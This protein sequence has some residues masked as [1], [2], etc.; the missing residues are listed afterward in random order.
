MYLSGLNRDS[1]EGTLRSVFRRDTIYVQLKSACYGVAL[2]WLRLTH[3]WI[4]DSQVILNKT[5]AI[6]DTITTSEKSASDDTYL[7]VSTENSIALWTDGAQKLGRFCENL[8]ARASKLSRFEQTISSLKGLHSKRPRSLSYLRTLDGSHRIQ[9][10]G[11]SYRRTTS[12]SNVADSFTSSPSFDLFD[13]CYSS[14]PTD[15]VVIEAVET[16][17][18]PVGVSTLH[19]IPRST[20]SE[21]TDTFNV[22]VSSAMARLT[23]V[24]KKFC[25]TI[26]SR[27]TEIQTSMKVVGLQKLGK[28]LEKLETASSMDT[29]HGSTSSDVECH[30]VATLNNLSDAI[31]QT[32]TW[33]A[34]VHG[35][36]ND[37]TESNSTT[38][39]TQNTHLCQ[40]NTL[41][42]DFS[43]LANEMQSFISC[44]TLLRQSSMKTL[45]KE[46]MDDTEE[47][48][49]SYHWIRADQDSSSRYLQSHILESRQH[50]QR[51]VQELNTHVMSASWD[52]WCQPDLEAIESPDMLDRVPTETCVN[53]YRDFAACLE[54]EVTRIGEDSNNSRRLIQIKPLLDLMWSKLH[55]RLKVIIRL[56]ETNQ[57]TAGA[58]AVRLMISDYSEPQQTHDSNGNLFKMS[59]E[60]IS[61]LRH[62][63]DDD[64]IQNEEMGFSSTL[65]IEVTLFQTMCALLDVVLSNP[66][67][68]FLQQV[69]NAAVERVLLLEFIHELLG[70]NMASTWEEIENTGSEDLFG[71][72]LGSLDKVIGLCDTFVN[73]TEEGSENFVFPG[74][75]PLPVLFLRAIKKLAERYNAVQDFYT[76]AEVDSQTEVRLT[77]LT[78]TCSQLRRFC[79]SAKE[80]M[81]SRKV[82]STKHPWRLAWKPY[83]TKENMA[84]RAAYLSACLTQIMNLTRQLMTIPVRSMEH[85]AEQHR[86][87]MMISSKLTWHVV[88]ATCLCCSLGSVLQ[89]EQELPQCRL[90]IDHSNVLPNAVNNLLNQMI[91]R[92][93]KVYRLQHWWEQLSKQTR[94]F[95]EATSKLCDQLPGY[96]VELAPVIHLTFVEWMNEELTKS[97]QTSKLSD[98]S[99]VVHR[100]LSS[101]Q[102]LDQLLKQQHLI[103]SVVWRLWE[104]DGIGD[105]LITQLRRFHSQLATFGPRFPVRDSFHL[106][107]WNARFSSEWT[108]L[109]SWTK[110]LLVE[111]TEC[112]HSVRWFEDRMTMF[113]TKVKS[114][115]RW[116][117]Q[118]SEMRVD[119][120][121]D[122]EALNSKLKHLELIYSEVTGSQATQLEY[123]DSGILFP[124]GD[125]SVE[126]HSLL[127]ILAVKRDQAYAMH[128]SLKR[129]LEEGMNELCSRLVTLVE[130][131]EIDSFSLFQMWFLIHL[132]NMDQ[133]QPGNQLVD[134]IER[135]RGNLHIWRNAYEKL[136]RRLPILVQFLEAHT[137]TTK[138]ALY[139]LSETWFALME[140]AEDAQERL[141]AKCIRYE[142]LQRHISLFE[143]E[144]EE[145]C[146]YSKSSDLLNY[147][148]ERSC[149]M[150]FCPAVQKRKRERFVEILFRLDKLQEEVTLFTMD[151]LRFTLPAYEACEQHVVEYQMN[152]LDLPGQVQRIQDKLNE[153]NLDPSMNDDP[154]DEWNQLN[155]QELQFFHGI[156][157]LEFLIEC[158]F[159]HHPIAI[160]EREK[161]NYFGCL[162]K[163]IGFLQ[164]K[165]SERMRVWFAA[166][167]TDCNP[168]RTCGTLDF[169]S[170]Y[171]ASCQ[172]FAD[173]LAKLKSVHVI[174]SQ[175]HQFLLDRMAL[176]EAVRARVMERAEAAQLHL[177]NI[178]QQTRILMRGCLISQR[179]VEFC[180]RK[181]V[182]DL[183]ERYNEDGSCNPKPGIT[184]V[185]D[186]LSDYHV[187]SNLS[188]EMGFE[189]KGGDADGPKDAPGLD[190]WCNLELDRIQQQIS[191]T[192]DL[193]GLVVMHKQQR[194]L[195]WAQ[196][197]HTIGN[198]TNHQPHIL[199][200][201]LTLRMKLLSILIQLNPYLSPLSMARW[202]E[203]YPNRPPATSC[204]RED[205]ANFFDRLFRLGNALK[206]I[207]EQRE[208][209]MNGPQEEIVSSESADS[210]D[211]KLSSL[212]DA[213]SKQMTIGPQLLSCSKL[214]IRMILHGD[215]HAT[216]HLLPLLS[217]LLDVNNRLFQCTT[218]VEHILERWFHFLYFRSQVSNQIL[219]NELERFRT[220]V[221]DENVNTF[222]TDD[223]I[224][225]QLTM[226]E[227]YE[228]SFSQ[229]C[230]LDEYI[231][232]PPSSAEDGHHRLFSDPV[233]IR[234]RLQ[235]KRIA[236][237][238]EAG[239]YHRAH[240][241]RVDAKILDAFS[242]LRELTTAT[243]SLSKRD[244][245]TLQDHSKVLRK[246]WV[247]VKE[248]YTE[249]G[250]AEASDRPTHIST[251]YPVVF[252]V[253]LTLVDSL[254][255]WCNILNTIL[256]QTVLSRKQVVEMRC[257]LRAI[258]DKLSILPDSG[259]NTLS[260]LPHPTALS[261][262]TS[263]WSHIEDS[264]VPHL[265]WML[266]QTERQSARFQERIDYELSRNLGWLKLLSL[267]AG[268]RNT[269]MDLTV[270]M[271][272]A[273]RVR[274]ERAQLLCYSNYEKKRNRIT[275]GI[276]QQTRLLLPT[277][278]RQSD[279]SQHHARIS[280]KSLLQQNNLQSLLKRTSMQYIRMGL[281]RMPSPIGTAE[282][283]QDFAVRLES[284]FEGCI[285]ELLKI[286]H[287]K[288]QPTPVPISKSDSCSNLDVNWPLPVD[289]WLRRLD[290]MESSKEENLVECIPEWLT[291]IKQL[292][293]ESSKVKVEQISENHGSPSERLHHRRRFGPS[294]GKTRVGLQN[295][296]EQVVTKIR[297]LLRRGN[298]INS[299][300]RHNQDWK[301]SIDH[302]TRMGRTTLAKRMRRD[303]IEKLRVLQDLR[304]EFDQVEKD[305][306]KHTWMSGGTIDIETT[307][308]AQRLKSIMNFGHSLCAKLE[309]ELSVVFQEDNPPSH[310]WDNSIHSSDTKSCTLCSAVAEFDESSLI[311]HHIPNDH[312]EDVQTP[313]VNRT[314]QSKLFAQ[315]LIRTCSRAPVD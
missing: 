65:C 16:E 215:D 285:F 239:E 282:I 62:L 149:L 69:E 161:A 24:R 236:E 135:L 26:C 28:L 170:Q 132:T 114:S 116:L 245:E 256:H 112:I 92:S 105:E 43:T 29:L 305:W 295:K 263:N 64:K 277:L 154:V 201:S 136:N 310:D 15:D 25:E 206:S 162:L 23:T 52:G 214:V 193:V 217:R 208:P 275:S 6:S 312:L 197:Q 87:C 1:V 203:N 93:G 34:Q 252:G 176:C 48:T 22:S 89:E 268:D 127:D 156:G 10:L 308:L 73:D 266:T 301:N 85:L 222:E 240:L 7:L 151:T 229:L 304:S 283:Y 42:K 192:R 45:E 224:E 264:S 213:Y 166:M 35:K 102:T 164:Q 207:D 126:T 281:L 181:C 255:L 183:T 128:N 54:A 269:Q 309:Q 130:D 276:L 141:L 286:T 185:F 165:I 18:D 138:E 122:V 233:S 311:F 61:R 98:P 205:G 259:C 198:M 306:V 81:S 39:Q 134:K 182:T 88:K 115:Q 72:I 76:P 49:N 94:C 109:I 202:L 13:W 74:L 91:I 218:V 248:L 84:T 188:E 280:N 118:N 160:T 110:D 57:N 147:S 169:Y 71:Q 195:L 243:C 204:N 53:S 260:V 190:E 131:P 4:R 83:S 251:S 225:D 140:V 158:A 41:R 174:H 223:G 70:L 273:R 30:F 101:S 262:F 12:W 82:L 294:P 153:L 120:E 180:Q 187:L 148:D 44:P 300:L 253:Q 289:D 230:N 292:L 168:W 21:D 196:T 146:R 108:R 220:R 14:A 155:Q 17:I 103:R 144:T 36:E 66:A 133:Q 63:L 267:A 296:L 234:W 145:F 171:M 297:S 307:V 33:L 250:H 184:D 68:N 221:G 211:W 143:Y 55:D 32:T 247:L 56:E 279:R 106:L 219:D 189:K 191:Q 265:G 175:M 258:L 104:L 19:T 242:S 298:E 159:A 157:E 100:M 75:M 167:E 90:L 96:P 226:L 8:K 290:A 284:A 3:Q 80:C 303:Q 313:T 227:D 50:L 261:P 200:T 249:F 31:E 235:Q 232:I 179:V 199:S 177:C 270:L 27:F 137:G 293:A 99:S 194:R 11:L 111:L 210:G 113:E 9:P 38:V 314:Q 123:S 274:F 288:K 302:L 124:A 40:L 238:S 178:V 79:N 119:Q 212:V 186:F 139:R 173:Q 299:R 163:S 67:W 150:Q 5:D 142:E 228:A 315:K 272:T 59:S 125:S 246:S 107:S 95:N 117:A 37:T 254:S 97:H 278:H 257:G 86:N 46:N 58:Q 237:S 47:P 231:L 241:T 121:T 2:L 60:S 20:E 129:A 216:K 152:L 291:D 287:L 78:M 172:H 271:D 244:T 51:A 77:V 209:Q